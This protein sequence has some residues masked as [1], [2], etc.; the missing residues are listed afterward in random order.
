MPNCGRRPGRTVFAALIVLLLAP[1]AR[2][3]DGVLPRVR[4]VATGG[5]I[6]NRTGGRLT[7]GMFQ[8]AATGATGIVFIDP[9]ALPGNGKGHGKG[10]EDN[11]ADTALTVTNILVTGDGKQLTATVAIAA[12]AKAGPRLVKVMTPNGETSS[13]LAATDTLTVIP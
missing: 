5:T 12:V 9:A 6:S 1:A 8:P 2:A 11:H 10:V 4:L 7:A 3:Q 13:V